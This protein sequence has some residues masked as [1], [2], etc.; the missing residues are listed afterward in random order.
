MDLLLLEKN[1]M[2]LSVA[3]NSSSRLV[4]YLYPFLE[5]GSRAA[6]PR[7]RLLTGA[8]KGKGDMASD[9]IP[10]ERDGS[11]D[12][13]MASNEPSPSSVDFRSACGLAWAGCQ[14][15]PRVGVNWLCPNLFFPLGARLF[16]LRWNCSRTALK[17]W[18]TPKLL[19]GLA[20]V[21][22]LNSR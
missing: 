12:V 15:I 13:N 19:Q 17:F 9:G 18:S 2:G 16:H 8:R 7:H 4:S 5:T 1:L 10:D 14:F 21:I 22:V 11:H 6:Q 3:R 20:L